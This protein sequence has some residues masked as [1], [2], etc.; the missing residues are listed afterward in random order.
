MTRPADPP[1]EHC[2]KVVTVLPTFCVTVLHFC[3]EW[4]ACMWPWPLRRRFPPNIESPPP[5][6]PPKS[7]AMKGF[8]T[9]EEFD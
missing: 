4:L 7:A 6:P 9:K 5:A 1:Q 3:E 2:V 8:L